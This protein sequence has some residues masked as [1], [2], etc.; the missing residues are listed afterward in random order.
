MNLQKETQLKG[1]RRR[2]GRAGRLHA[3]CS[4]EPHQADTSITADQPCRHA[5]VSSMSSQ[6]SLLLRGESH[7]PPSCLPQL[8]CPGLCLGGGDLLRSNREDQKP[9][10]W[11]VRLAPAKFPGHS[12]NMAEPRHLMPLA[13]TW[14]TVGFLGAVTFQWAALGSGQKYSHH[15]TVGASASRVLIHHHLARGKCSV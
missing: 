2:E 3:P 7:F 10:A 8:C 14:R 4:W 1:W 15:A 13:R 9:A 11:D 6:V 12:P 5:G